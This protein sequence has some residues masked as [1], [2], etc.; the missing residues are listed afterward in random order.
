[1]KKIIII[2][3]KKDVICPECK[4]NAFI[5][6]NN[7]QIS[8][9]GC[10]NEHSINNILFVNYENSQIVPTDKTKYRNCK[11]NKNNKDL[12]KCLS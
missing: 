7:Y 6:I 9:F 11:K 4:E 8:L 10:K 3:K 2:Q 1:M 12:Y 5:N